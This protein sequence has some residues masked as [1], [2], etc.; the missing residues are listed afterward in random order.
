M[1]AQQPR[2]TPPNTDS[3]QRRYRRLL[4]GL[5]LLALILRLARLTF[6]PLW[7]DEG[8]SLYFATTDLG[9]MLQRTAVDIHPPFYYL[10]L[11]LWTRLLGPGVVSVRLLSVLIGTATVPLLAAVGRRL[12]GSAG[13]LL[14]AALLAISPFH[15]YYAQEIRM[16]G[17][18]TLLGLAATYFAL[19]R[20]WAARSW[21]GYVLAAT[22]ALYTQYYAAFLLLGLNLVVLI[23][24]LRRDRGRRSFRRL[25]P[26]L[27]AQATVALLF[28]PWAWYA[29]DKLL[30]YVRFKVSVEQD[31]S[32]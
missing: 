2:A 28:L 7:W 20:P 5:V 27:A 3:Q 1:C 18:V 8:W 31:P 19:R 30:T 25:L 10:L 29:G 14:A 11:H 16:Y 12:L 6:Q 26:W 17:L 15:I 23:H 9:T 32:L 4:A 22:A 24:W 21:L 13:A